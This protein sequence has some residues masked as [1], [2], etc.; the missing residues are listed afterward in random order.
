[1]IR[2]FRVL[3]WMMTLPSVLQES[4]DSKLRQYQEER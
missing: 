4:F 2:F 3:D 1:M